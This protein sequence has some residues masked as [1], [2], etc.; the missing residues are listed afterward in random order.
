[1]YVTF[2]FTRLRKREF[3]WNGN[4]EDLFNLHEGKSKNNI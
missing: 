4:R 3:H 2:D 1:M